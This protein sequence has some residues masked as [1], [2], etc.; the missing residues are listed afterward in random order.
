MYRTGDLGRLRADGGVEYINRI[1]SQFMI[2]GFRIE[3]GEIDIYITQHPFVRENVTLIRRDKDEESTLVTYFVPEAK[4]L[5]QHL[6]QD[7]DA[8]IIERNIQHESMTN[9]LKHFKSLCEDFKNFLATEV[10]NY[11]IPIFFY[12]IGSDALE[13]VSLMK[14]SVL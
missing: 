2:R 11:A 9:M 12:S 6:Q 1:N 8:K 5:F 10:P 7:E 14:Q 13:Y 3:L 4:R